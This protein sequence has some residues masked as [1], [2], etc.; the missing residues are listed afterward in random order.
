MLKP[1]KSDFFTKFAAT[2][3]PTFRNHCVSNTCQW[4]QQGGR[5]QQAVVTA[6][7][8]PNLF[9]TV[10][11]AFSYVENG[12]SLHG[13]TLTTVTPCAQPLPSLSGRGWGWGR[14]GLCCH[15]PTIC[16]H[17]CFPFVQR[18]SA[19]LVAEWQQKQ[20]KNFFYWCPTRVLFLQHLWH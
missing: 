12:I 3:P 16:H 13:S 9:T 4:W 15:S 11:T 8:S 2:L 14:L 20:E 10:K 1:P 17:L 6:N 18:V 19:V 7:D 5:W